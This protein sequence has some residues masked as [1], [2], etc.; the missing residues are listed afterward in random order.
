MRT[1]KEFIKSLTK[2]DIEYR[3]VEKK[4]EVENK[5]KPKLEMVSYQPENI[6]RYRI[7]IKDDYNSQGWGWGDTITTDN[8][9]ISI[10]LSLDD[11]L[12]NYSPTAMKKESIE[13]RGESYHIDG[14]NLYF[15]FKPISN[16][17]YL[18]GKYQLKLVRADVIR[19][20]R[21]DSS[22]YY[23]IGYK[24][25]I[26]KS[27]TVSCKRN[28]CLEIVL[29]NKLLDNKLKESTISISALQILDDIRQLDYFIESLKPSILEGITKNIEEEL[30]LVEEIKEKERK[31]KEFEET[32]NE[33]V[34]REHFISLIDMFDDVKIEKNFSNIQNEDVF[35][36]LILTEPDEYNPYQSYIYAKEVND[37]TKN[38]LFELSESI[39]RFDEFFNYICKTDL[40]MYASNSSNSITLNFKLKNENKN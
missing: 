40:L 39:S 14:C 17:T 15:S 2:N 27:Y 5:Q 32:I 3:E 7:Q 29:D 10:Y 11:I 22:D 20:Y 18:Q 1:L 23:G 30:K 26:K 28:P 24:N 4:H 19:E 6:S 21:L 35:Y 37:R 9:L 8:K 31:I 12:S 33:S 36:S 16:N 25:L 34:I 13:V 38:L